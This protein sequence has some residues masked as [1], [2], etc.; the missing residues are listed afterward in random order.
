MSS[1]NENY[2]AEYKGVP[3]SIISDELGRFQV[4]DP[5]IKPISEVKERIVGYAFTVNAMA[6]CNWG[7]HIALYKANRNNVI[8]VDGKGYRKNSIWGG[9]QSYVAVRRGIRATIIDGTV[10]DKNDHIDLG[11][12]ICSRGVTPAG[13]HKGWKDELQVPISCGGVVVNPGD[14]III[15]EDGIVVVPKAKIVEI[16]ERTQAR[17]NQEKEWKKRI[18]KGEKFYQILGLDKK[19]K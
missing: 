18:D 6:G 7:T 16:F 12:C 10:R 15:D 11:Y 4:M 3:T 14:L 2:L 9:L 17:I 19:F 8:V 1:E 13:P 5:E